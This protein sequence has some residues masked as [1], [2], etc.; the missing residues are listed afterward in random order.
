[1]NGLDEKGYGIFQDELEK[2]MIRS[3]MRLDDN[4]LDIG[5]IIKY[6]WRKYME[7]ANLRVIMRGKSIGMIESQIRKELID[8]EQGTEARAG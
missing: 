6:M 4:P 8:L 1:M 5:V 3:A 7:V 2:F